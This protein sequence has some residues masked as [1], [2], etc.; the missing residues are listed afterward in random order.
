MY[1]HHYCSRPTR[2]AW[3][4]SAIP[5]GY[6]YFVPWCCACGQPVSSCR[7][8]ED[9]NLRLYLPQELTVDGSSAAAQ[10]EIVVGGSDDVE[11][12]LETLP[13]SGAATPAVTLE[14]VDAA[15]TTLFQAAPIPAGYSVND[16]LADVTPGTRLRLKADGCFAR[17][18]WC[19]QMEY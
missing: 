18:R 10:A 4:P 11:P 9:E 15:V 8:G 1:Y 5:I 17:L 16:G 19:E 14:K 6:Y 13:A 3:Q 12:I 7:C 2:A